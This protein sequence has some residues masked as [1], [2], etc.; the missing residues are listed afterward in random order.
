MSKENQITVLKFGSSVLGSDADLSLVV[1]EIARW[2][3]RGHR[4]VAVVSAIGNTTDALT[5]RAL[6]IST[7]PVDS[8][9]A[10]LLATGETESAALLG[11][12]LTEAGIKATVLDAVQAGLFT[13][14][15]T[16]DAALKDVK[17]S[18]ILNALETDVVVIPGFVGRDEH[19]PTT[20]LGRGGSDLSALF[21]ADRL[22]ADC[23]LVKDVDGLYTSD[24]NSA[25]NRVADRF[26]RVSYD[27]TLR[28]GGAVVQRKAVEFAQAQRLSFYISSIDSQFGTEVGPF[29]DCIQQVEECAA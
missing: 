15:S 17:T 19:N 28:I 21:I 6:A 29:E 8:F 16:L 2:R 3:R 18:V 23:R 5:Q 26:D 1:K 9:I 24:P 25:L 7:Q 13:S 4:L 14:G 20:L 10:S 27:T 12:A 11:I 22:G